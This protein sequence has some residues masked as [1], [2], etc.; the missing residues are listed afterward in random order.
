MKGGHY[1][2]LEMNARLIFM[3]TSLGMKWNS[4]FNSDSWCACRR[5]VERLVTKKSPCAFIAEYEGE[6]GLITNIGST[7]ITNI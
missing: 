6:S 1:F 5:Q 2:A 3:L 4:E 7:I